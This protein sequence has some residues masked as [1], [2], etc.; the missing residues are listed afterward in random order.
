MPDDPS[1]PAFAAP[2]SR[3]V[4]TG[5]GEVHVVAGAAPELLLLHG[6]GHSWHEWAWVIDRLDP[7]MVA[8][9]DMPG[10][11]DS[12]SLRPRPSVPELAAAA[13]A[14]VEDIGR[15][16]VVAGT[17]IGAMV[18]VQLAVTRPELVNAV[19][20]IEAQL[21]TARW[22]AQAWPL[23]EQL[24]AIPGQS[25]AEVAARFVGEPDDALVARWNID[26]HRAGSRSMMGVMWAIRHFDLAAAAAQL[27]VPTHLV[28]GAAGPARD[29]AD[30]LAARIPVTARGDV[31]N[32]DRAGHFVTL[33]RPDA[34]AALLQR[35]AA[36]ARGAGEDV[37]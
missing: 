34:I 22:W 20:A 19:V 5:L 27:A 23:V 28:Y 10:H 17:S 31:V 14:V 2:W 18:A 26:R 24:F 11:G 1:A 12:E 29:T 21:R 15:P 36:T 6:N 7:A 33:E 16:V 13:A 9:W 8:A 32:V 37:R 35:V 30:A 3:V 25:R 4:T